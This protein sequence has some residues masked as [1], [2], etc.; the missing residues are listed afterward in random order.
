MSPT[1]AN[2]TTDKFVVP[3]PPMPDG[4][5]V[6][7]TSTGETA[8]VGARVVYKADRAPGSPIRPVPLV[9]LIGRLIRI[10]Q[11]LTKYI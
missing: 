6:L 9:E 4:K 3:K 1:R 11:T 5:G 8:E 7:G 10:K 2:A